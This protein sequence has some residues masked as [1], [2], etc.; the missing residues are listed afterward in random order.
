MHSIGCNSK[1]RAEHLHRK[2]CGSS[3]L[4]R[5]I[6]TSCQYAALAGGAVIGMDLRDTAFAPVSASSQSSG[7]Q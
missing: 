4:G 3:I 2:V 5:K 6:Y 1:R 7:Q